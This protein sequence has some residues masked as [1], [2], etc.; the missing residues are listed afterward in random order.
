MLENVK[1]DIRRYIVTEDI[2][3]T[4]QLLSMYMENFSL[5]YILS[6]RF[7]RWVRQKCRV[8]FLRQVLMVCTRMTH[9]LLSLLTGIQI[10][11]DAK[12]GK[13]LYIGHHGM[14]IV[15]GK[16]VIGDYCN[17]G[18]GVVIGQGGRRENRGVPVLGNKVYVGVGAKIIGKIQIGDEVAVGANAV[19]TKDVPSHVTVAGIPARII[20]Q[21]GSSNFIR[22][23]NSR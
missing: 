13:G 8:P 2:A 16:V 6:Y 22:F 18:P 5:W 14:L 20:N 3:T 9:N 1:E 23:N 4:R 15:N 21:N 10:G 11:F 19:V 7:G 17:L 12:I